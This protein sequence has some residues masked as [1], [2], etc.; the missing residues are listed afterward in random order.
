MIA[1]PTI[2]ILAAGHSRRLGCPKALAR[3]HGASLLRR[4]ARLLAPLTCAALVVIVPPKCGRYLRELRGCRVR[5]LRNPGRGEGLAASVRLGVRSARY[6]PAALLVPADLA[7]LSRSEIARLI[8]RWRAGRRRL[9]ARRIDAAGG[10]GRRGGASGGTPLILPKR[11]YAAALALRGD[12]G[13]RAVVAALADADRR[14]VSMPSAA[15]DVDTPEDLA[16]ARRESLSAAQGAG[17]WTSR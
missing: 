10:S 5:L 16:R 4:T 1:S 7:A 6:A 9:V 15:A 2:V 3:V 14:L 11:F 8:G 13:L 12:T 17:V